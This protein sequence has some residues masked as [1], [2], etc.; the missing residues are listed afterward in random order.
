MQNK[1]IIKYVDQV[2]NK[3]DVP[4]EYK[5]KLENELIRNI[6]S[7]SDDPDIKIADVLCSPEK[8]A[9]EL[10]SKFRKG[11]PADT[12]EHRWNEETQCYHYPP[13]PPPHHRYSGDLMLEHNNMSL[14]LL[15][16][17]LLQVSSGTERMTMPLMEGY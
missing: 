16:I 3:T 14:K 17:P 15:Y 11:Y 7:A 4:V 9:E 2:M 6:I 13:P 5:A 10:T 8:L 12:A 1:D